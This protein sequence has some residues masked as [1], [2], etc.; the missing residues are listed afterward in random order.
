[1]NY[2]LTFGIKILALFG[3]IIFGMFLILSY[4]RNHR[5]HKKLRP[6]RKNFWLFILIALVSLMYINQAVN[7][8]P[9]FDYFMHT[10][11][12]ADGPQIEIKNAMKFLANADEFRFV[13]EIAEDPGN[14]PKLKNTEHHYYTIKAE[15]VINEI[16]PRVFVNSWTFNGKIPGPMMRAEV[17]DHVTITLKNNESSLHTHSIDLHAV[18]GPGGGA[19]VM[20][21]PPGEEKTF[22]F[23]AL[24]PGVYIYHC[25]TPNVGVHMTHGMYGLIVIEPEGG[26]PEVDKEFYVVQGEAYTSGSIGNRGLQIFDAKRYLSGDPTYVVFNG[27]KESLNG[28]MTANVGDTVRIYIGNGGVNLVSS[29]HVIGE[30]FDTVY[31][32][33]GTPVQKN[34]QSTVIPAGGASIVEF[35]VEL[36]GNYLLVDHSLAR[37]DKGI[38]GILNVY[39]DV[40]SDI[41][42]PMPPLNT[43]MENTK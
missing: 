8:V 24:N 40:N 21:V 28:K 23:K 35:D 1:M 17:G 7:T 18:T 14:V 11:G 3:V 36:P 10:I 20:Q 34:I 27:R 39:G 9:S 15:E 37:L 29:F 32:E 5:H 42:N 25:A 38:W 4:I 30:I 26:L 43:V 12:P 31:P 13:E 2:L 6:Y 22:T 19:A 41:M 16:A 33:G